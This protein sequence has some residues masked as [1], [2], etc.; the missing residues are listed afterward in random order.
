[1]K[2]TK[3]NIM[4]IVFSHLKGA[5][6]LFWIAK[7]SKHWRTNLE[8]SGLL[9]QSKVIKVNSYAIINEAINRGIKYGLRVINHVILTFD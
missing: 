7:L 8:N 2:G 9:D 3:T 5:D 6:L 4:M 1:M